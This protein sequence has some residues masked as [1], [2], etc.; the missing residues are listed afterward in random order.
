M[1]NCITVKL[2]D[3]DSEYLLEEK[4]DGGI[5]VK[6]PYLFKDD[7]NIDVIMHNIVEY[8][9]SDKAEIIKQFFYEESPSIIRGG[10]AYNLAEIIFDEADLPPYIEQDEIE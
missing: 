5:I 6:A 7:E 9:K 1:T 10:I 8:K 2:G 4:K 3:F